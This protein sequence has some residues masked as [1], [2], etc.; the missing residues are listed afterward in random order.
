MLGLVEKRD[1]NTVY[2]AIKHGT[3][4]QESKAPREGYDP[5]EVVNP[6]TKAVTVKY[7]KPYDRV[8]A[9]IKDIEF[10]EHEWEG[11]TFRSW[12]LSLDANGTPCVLEIPI[13]S[14]VASRFMKCAENIS[15]HKPVEFRAW[16]DKDGK[17]AIVL[18]QDGVKV[19]QKYSQKDPGDCPEPVRKVT[20]K[21]NFDAQEEFLFERMFNVVIPKLRATAVMAHQNGHEPEADEDEEAPF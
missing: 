5:V 11:R 8:E 19:D 6:E 12:R 15:F 16:L 17:T 20:G 1:A 7:I 9:M 10:R 4:C 14:R 13:E 3:L 18:K 2:L 21:W